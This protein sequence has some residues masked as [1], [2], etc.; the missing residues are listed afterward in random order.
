MIKDTNNIMVKQSMNPYQWFCVYFN[1]KDINNSIKFYEQLLEHKVE[2]QFKT[3]WAEFKI[4]EGFTFGLLSPLFDKN[5]ISK[6]EDL[7]QH[8]DDNYIRNFSEK[9]KLGNNAILN[10]TTDNIKKDRERVKLIRPKALSVSKIMYINFMF[11]YY[12]FMVKDPDGNLI[13]I[14]QNNPNQK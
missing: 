8:Y 7:S 13:E 9:I 3:R 5:Y 10:L 14:A 11:P 4:C 2:R 1:V 6:N 12:F